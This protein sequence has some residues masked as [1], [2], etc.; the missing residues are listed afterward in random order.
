MKIMLAPDSFKGSMT[1]IEA[2]EAMRKGIH[3]YDELIEVVSFPL[4]DGGEGTLEALT[5]GTEM[6]KVEADT[7][8][9]LGRPMTG[10]YAYDADR[11]LA[12]IETAIASGLTLLEE[13][14]R[15]PLLASTEGTGIL[16]KD[17]V[18]RGATEIVIGIGGSAT[19]DGGTGFLQGIGIRFYDENDQLLHR[20]GGQLNRIR[21][22][23]LSGMIPLPEGLTVKVASDVTNR[24][25]GK[26]GAVYVFGP[27]KGLEQDELPEFEA[28]MAGFADLAAKTLGT[29]H[30]E[31]PGS[32][33]AGGLGFA[34]QAFLGAELRRG[35]DMIAESVGIIEAIHNADLIMSGEGKLDEQTLFGKGPIGV[36]TIAADAGKPVLLF[37]G[38]RTRSFDEKIRDWDHVVSYSLISENGNVTELM[39]EGAARLEDE[40]YRVMKTI[41]I[42]RGW[43]S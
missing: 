14:E 43:G 39:A 25:L 15:N 35:F 3:R 2:A 12:V 19:V 6:K 42:G 21:R 41:D 37:G 8:D 18:E 9:P 31:S 20:V 7:I 29:D 32:G 22:M 10:W 4:A 34:L 33:A 5:Y 11:S 40:V 17:A 1:S 36:A 13:E 24:L 30:R 23:D 26:E 38:M 16:F 27:Q 28:G